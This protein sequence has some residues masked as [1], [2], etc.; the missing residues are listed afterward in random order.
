MTLLLFQKNTIGPR[1]LAKHFNPPLLKQLSQFGKALRLRRRGS[2]WARIAL[3]VFVGDVLLAAAV[4][5]AV[6]FFLR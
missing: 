2:Q 6:D 5:I 1:I 3:L 4:W